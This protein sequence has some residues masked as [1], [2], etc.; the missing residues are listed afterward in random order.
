[1]AR[2]HHH[3]GASR[4]THLRHADVVILRNL[5]LNLVDGDA[6]ARRAQFVAQDV[7][8]AVQRDLAPAQRRMSHQA[9]QRAFQLAH[10]ARDLVSEELENP[11]RNL[12]F[13]P[14]A[15]HPRL[16]DAQPQF[17]GG[18]VNLR[19]QTRTEAG[20]HPL[21][22]IFQVARQAVAR[23]DDLLPVGNQRIERVK[24]FFLRRILAADELHVVDQ[25]QVH[26]TDALLEPHDALEAQGADE[27]V[28][29]PLGAEIDDPPLGP[30][31]PRAQPDRVHQMRLAQTDA[32]MDVEGVER[33]IVGLRHVQRRR[34]GELVG[35]A[36]DEGLETV[37]LVQPGSELAVAHRR[38][39]AGGRRTRPAVPRRK[40][41]T[42]H[43]FD[44]LYRRDLQPPQRPYP[45]AV[46]RRH[47]VTQEARG[48]GQHHPPVVG[49]F[50]FDR[51]DPALEGAVAQLLAQ[52]VPHPP[53]MPV[54]RPAGADRTAPAASR[55]GEIRSLFAVGASD[56]PLP[57]PPPA[58][59]TTTADT[60]PTNTAP[61]GQCSFK[62]APVHDKSREDLF[63][64]L[65][66]AATRGRLASSP[67]NCNM[68]VTFPARS[69]PVRRRRP[70]SWPV[71]RTR[72]REGGLQ[73]LYTRRQAG[74]FAPHRVARDDASGDAA[75]Q[76]RLGGAERG[77]RRRLV[78]G[79]DRRL[80]RFER[81]ADT[82][83]PRPVDDPPALIAPYP[84]LRRFVV[85][86]RDLPSK[87][88]APGN[89]AVITPARRR[90]QAAR[91]R[92]AARHTRT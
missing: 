78:V 23:H 27:L 83:A 22:H 54:E 41:R 55:P 80:D 26:R 11:G 60:E 25:Q 36:D 13:L 14:H 63:L 32:A 69:P 72:Q 85:R 43:E 68:T 56:H 76:L 84:L 46:A 64:F 35:F 70:G 20:T 2:P 52:L 47:P 49:R 62:S 12:R 7:L 74:Q 17:V 75:H 71:R 45:V 10:A 15:L 4:R 82:P 89:A 21:L 58:H 51:L 67:R 29:E 79:A 77:F 73:R 92:A 34:V 5:L 66:A 59:R 6:A 28:H 19:R 65:P 57:S 86:H 39:G 37:F 33:D 61:K 18:R 42:H 91:R 24:E 50:E 40:R 87:P 81:G 30:Q 44:R 9:R 88:P 90:G 16:Q 8:T 1:M 53:P 38:R 48:R 31:R 3:L